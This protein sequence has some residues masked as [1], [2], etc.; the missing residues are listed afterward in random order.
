MSGPRHYDDGHGEWDALAVGWAMS[1]LDP[2]DE[3]ILLPHLAVCDRCT[4]LVAE[5]TLTVGDIG[6]SVPDEAPPPELRDRLMAAVR[7]EPRVGGGAPPI[8]GWAP[9]PPGPPGPAGPS[10][11]LGPPARPGPGPDSWR[12][13]P[14][15]VP[16]PA[17]DVVPLAPRRARRWQPIT[18]AA[19]AAA[20]V[21]GL[22]GWNVK[23][24]GD[25]SD[26]RGSL[27]QRNEVITELTRPGVLKV[28][29]IT[30]PGSDTE[31]GM[32]ITRADGI[33]LFANG[34]PT[35]AGGATQYWLWALTGPTDAA[36]KP[37][38]AFDVTGNG[39]T[40]QVVSAGGG[41][42]EAPVY[43]IST[44]ARGSHPL[45]PIKVVGVGASH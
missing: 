1:A 3:A 29:P 44:E 6:F 43:A 11:P 15:P 25:Q 17:G 22:A 41:D 14:P 40:A 9:P 8:A 23:L 26:L 10:G 5:T 37:L 18:A 28:A 16:P 38:A 32:I 19:A 39:P 45:K 34:L 30:P 2:E 42:L 4:E 31:L 20:L 7:N 36:P 21:V 35:T 24:H 13:A 12:S 27:A 33:T